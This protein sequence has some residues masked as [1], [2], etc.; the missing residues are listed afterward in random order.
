MQQLS[1]G[2]LVLVLGA[3]G[4]GHCKP[5]ASNHAPEFQDVPNLILKV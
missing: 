5:P 3:V 4:H 1:D 2:R